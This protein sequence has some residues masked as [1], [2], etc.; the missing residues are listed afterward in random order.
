M[1]QLY[2]TSSLPKLSDYCRS[3]AK[4]MEEPKVMEDCWKII[5]PNV[6][7]T[8]MNSAQGC[9]HKTWRISRHSALQHGDGR[10]S[11][12]PTPSSG[13][14]FLNDVAPGRL[15]MLQQVALKPC[16]FRQLDSA[17]YT[18]KIK[19]FSLACH[20]HSPINFLKVSFDEPKAH[21]LKMQLA[22]LCNLP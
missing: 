9:Q 22:Q 2:D 17:G 16:A 1:R 5:V 7:S 4:R 6:T 10:G 15:P 11:R 19:I 13:A 12:A 21:I 14:A 20:S 3:G 18:Q 8:L